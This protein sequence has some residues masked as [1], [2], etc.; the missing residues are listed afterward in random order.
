MTYRDTQIEFVSDAH[1]LCGPA[2]TASTGE[3]TVPVDYF[4]VSVAGRVFQVTRFRHETCGA[5]GCPVRVFILNSDG[6]RGLL[7]NGSTP[8]IEPRECG[9]KSSQLLM[10]RDGRSLTVAHTLFALQWN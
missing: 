1:N 3:M 6:S 8:M 5:K 10:S 7:V 2:R 9:E 4:D